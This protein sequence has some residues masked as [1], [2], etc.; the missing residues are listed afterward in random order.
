MPARRFGRSRMGLRR[1]SVCAALIQRATDLRSAIGVFLLRRI[2]LGPDLAFSRRM[3]FVEARAQM[4]E[5]HLAG[6][7]ISDARLLDAFRAVPREAFV[8]AELAEFAYETRRF[9]SAR[10]RRSRSRTSSR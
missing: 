2:G 1:A 8:P 5:L 6:R 7:G 9:R 4:V 3:S 10:D